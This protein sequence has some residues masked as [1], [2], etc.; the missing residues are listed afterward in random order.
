MKVVTLRSGNL[1]TAPLPRLIKRPQRSPGTVCR[2]MDSIIS[3]DK[4]V[5]C[6]CTFFASLD[7]GFML[8]MED[9][10]TKLPSGGLRRYCSLR[11]DYY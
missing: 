3:I 10:W 7:L 1:I 5:T 9:W 2:R 4:T 11:L 8:M 6:Y